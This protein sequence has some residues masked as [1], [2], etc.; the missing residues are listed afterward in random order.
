MRNRHHATI[1][2]LLLYCDD[3]IVTI[4][5]WRTIVHLQVVC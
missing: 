4:Y 3:F 2:I 1:Y 5:Y